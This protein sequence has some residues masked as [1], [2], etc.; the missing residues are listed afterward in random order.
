MD[1]P[2]DLAA[3]RK[4]DGGLRKPAVFQ[5][6]IGHDHVFQCPM[7]LFDQLMHFGVSR[8]MDDEVRLGIIYAPDSLGVSDVRDAQILKNITEAIRPG[9]GPVVNA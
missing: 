3:A 6:V 2:I 8:Q 7:R 9:V 1:I 5:D 4:Y